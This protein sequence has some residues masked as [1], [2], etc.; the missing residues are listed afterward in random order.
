MSS[1]P[2]D[3]INKYVVAPGKD[4]RNLIHNVIQL[5]RKIGLKMGCPTPLKII[6]I[7]A[8]LTAVSIFP[9]QVRGQQRGLFESHLTYTIII[10]GDGSGTVSLEI[11]QPIVTVTNAGQVLRMP[12]CIAEQPSSPTQPPPKDWNRQIV[13]RNT[14]KDCIVTSSESAKDLKTL[15]QEVEELGGSIT[16]R[17][18]SLTLRISRHDPSP[19]SNPLLRQTIIYRY[20]ITIPSLETFSA[21]GV[22]QGANQVVWTIMTTSHSIEIKGRLNPCESNAKKLPL[23]RLTISQAGIDYIRNKETPVPVPYN[24]AANNCTVGIGHKLHSGPCLSQEIR[25]Y[26]PPEMENL[27][28]SDIAKA[29]GDVKGHIIADVTQGQLDALTS[30]V[31]NAG[32]LSIAPRLVQF[33]NNGQACEAANELLD[34]DKITNPDTGKKESL[35]ALTARRKEESRMFLK[36]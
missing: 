2:P 8:G 25:T 22:K 33:T 12:R 35:P 34:I 1:G 29:E 30:L 36:R 23:R 6:A 11:S 9:R 20:V 31:F 4:Q 5:S 13:V 18:G 28:S 14:G 15:S 3:L 17:D 24:D 26:S 16:N 27:F 19:P 21:N 7:I 32:S 10:R